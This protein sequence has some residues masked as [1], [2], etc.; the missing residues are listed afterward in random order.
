M[1]SLFNVYKNWTWALDSQSTSPGFKTARL[2]Q[3]KLILSSSDV[4]K[5]EPGALSL[6]LVV[7]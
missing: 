4:N 2:L 5:K 6:L 1:Q 7:L 3:G